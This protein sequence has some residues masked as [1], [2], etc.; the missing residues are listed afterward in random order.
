M[1]APTPL[2]ISPH[3]NPFDGIAHDVDDALDRVLRSDED[4]FFFLIGIPGSGKTT[5]KVHYLNPYPFVS[6]DTMVIPLL[7]NRQN[8]E[9]YVREFNLEIVNQMEH[10]LRAH[11][12]SEHEVVVFEEASIGLSAFRPHFLSLA[13]THGYK[14]VLIY[15][16]LDK[17]TAYQRNKQR[18]LGMSEEGQI[19]VPEV[20]IETLHEYQ[21]T[22]F[23]VK[24]QVSSSWGKAFSTQDTSHIPYLV[25]HLTSDQQKIINEAF[26][27]FPTLVPGDEQFK[28]HLTENDYADEVW[29]IDSSGLRVLI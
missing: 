10:T 1:N 15:F 8:C 18:S 7:R 29:T 13:H 21:N 5:F 28:A 12:L 26:F 6:Y 20:I 27:R 14:T 17:V 11:L 24:S 4:V 19:R 16:P 23:Q 9:E 2:K 25:N 22:R 3:V